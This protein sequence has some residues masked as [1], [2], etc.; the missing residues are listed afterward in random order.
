MRTPRAPFT[1]N[2]GTVKRPPYTSDRKRK[3]VGPSSVA[4]AV[5]TT[6][7]PSGPDL[8]CC[9]AQIKF[10]VGFTPT[11][12]PVYVQ[13]PSVSRSHNFDELSIKITRAD[14]MS[15]TDTFSLSSLC[16]VEA[17]SDL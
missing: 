12:N 15:L 9:R 11:P 2:P 3:S 6:I 1:S 17:V 13:S 16:H 14:Y 7:M 5:D 4:F 8:C 10:E